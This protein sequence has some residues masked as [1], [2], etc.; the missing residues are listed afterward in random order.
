MRPVRCLLGAHQYERFY[1]SPR[2]RHWRC[3][4]CGKQPRDVTWGTMWIALAAGVV[5]FYLFFGVVS[6][7]AG[8]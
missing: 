3:A 5:V 7:L 4:R 1:L 6:E 2:C 8:P